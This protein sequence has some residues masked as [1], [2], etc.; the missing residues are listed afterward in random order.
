MIDARTSQFLLDLHRE[1]RLRSATPF[2]GWTLNRLR[3]LLPFDSG[4]WG[5][6][7][8]GPIVIHDVHVHDQPEAMMANYARVAKHDFFAAASTSMPGKTINLYDV[9]ERQDFV[10]HTMYL[11]HAK[12]FGM[13]HMLCTTMPGSMEGYIHF[14]SLWRASYDEP[15]TEADRALKEHLMPHLIEAR[16][17]NV[18][19][20]IRDQ[21][22]KHQA[23]EFVAALCGTDGVLHEVQDG[24]GPML[25]RMDTTW[26]GATLPR[27]LREAMRRKA[28]GRLSE[29]GV[30]AEW[31][32]WEGRTV[33]C[34]HPAEA[35]DQL[36]RREAQIA[37]LLAEGKS[38]RDAAAALGV[39]T[40]TVRTHVYSLYR[41]L[42]CT[43]KAEMIRLVS[44]GLT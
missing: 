43:N 3:E 36:S 17:V 9:I 7:R 20:G 35:I 24:F 4:M 29:G 39:S 40:N 8:S 16:R 6:G 5:Q 13:E 44:R 32:A 14:V 37:H 26:K 25:S 10:R 27:P 22:D 28:R 23:R 33:V 12:R 18:L 15:Y 19:S 42:G 2:V 1:C 41:K 21:V 31:F 38:H 34:L 11:Q 30:T